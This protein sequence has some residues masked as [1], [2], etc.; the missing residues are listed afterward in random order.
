MLFGHI[1][2][3]ERKMKPAEPLRRLHTLAVPAPNPNNLVNNLVDKCLALQQQNQRLVVEAAELAHTVKQQRYIRLNL[4]RNMLTMAE[5]LTAYEP[6]YTS[7]QRRFAELLHDEK[8]NLIL[9]YG[10]DCLEDAETDSSP[11]A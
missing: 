2:S 3:Y 6:D 11:V 8:I 10:T 1:I 9:E 7:A 5:R 4:Y